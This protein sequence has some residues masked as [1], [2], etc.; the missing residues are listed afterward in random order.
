MV[1]GHEALS[2]LPSVA[3]FWKNVWERNPSWAALEAAAASASGIA[4][5]PGA[6]SPLAELAKAVMSG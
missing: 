5:A 6:Y 3:L 4:A 1:A 2:S